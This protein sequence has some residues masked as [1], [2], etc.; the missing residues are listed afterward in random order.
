[1]G[2]ADPAHDGEAEAADG[3]G[4][5]RRFVAKEAI[6]DPWAV[7]LG[8]AA[9]AVRHDHANEAGLWRERDLDRRAVGAVL[10]RVVDEIEADQPQEA[11]VAEHLEAGFDPAGDADTAFGCHLFERGGRLGHQMRE[12]E[13]LADDRRFPAGLLPGESEQALDH[14]LQA[15]DLLQVLA[16]QRLI[17]LG[18]ARAAQRDL[19][20]GLWWRG[21][22]SAAG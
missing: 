2:L 8:Y 19:E 14:A 5:S 4:G 22:P 12:V 16:Q 21:I 11:L 7:R 3:V 18:R 6:E 15:V 17:L 10:E 13:P 9:P 20:A 1:M